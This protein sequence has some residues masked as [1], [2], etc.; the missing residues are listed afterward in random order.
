MDDYQAM[1]AL[2][3]A[4]GRT[5]DD[6]MRESVAPLYEI[7]RDPSCKH[8]AAG[9]CEA[10]LGRDGGGFREEQAVFDMDDFMPGDFDVEEEIFSS[11]SMVAE[12]V[13]EVDLL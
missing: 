3:E 11:D 2:G 1:D 12:A 13:E 8:P 10:D 9:G 5:V 7:Q 6:L 4:G